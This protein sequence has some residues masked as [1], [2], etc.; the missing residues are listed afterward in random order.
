[1]KKA[2]A[3]PAR[4]ARDIGLFFTLPM[5]MYSATDDIVNV[6]D[7]LFEVLST[8]VGPDMLVK[9]TLFCRRTGKFLDDSAASSVAGIRAYHGAMTE[10][11]G[12]VCAARDGEEI[13]PIAA[14]HPR[15]ASSV[16][17]DVVPDGQAASLPPPVA[18]SAVAAA[19]AGEPKGIERCI[20]ATLE[21]DPDEKFCSETEKSTEEMGNNLFRD[22]VWTYRFHCLL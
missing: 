18:S 14:H 5:G 20:T 2:E 8:K 6:A 16:G 7:A 1:M 15:L 19:P 17:A 21:I 22:K 13:P 3:V 10:G 11:V 12:D 4:K 9:N